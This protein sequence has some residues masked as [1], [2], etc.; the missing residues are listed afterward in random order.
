MYLFAVQLFAMESVAVNIHTVKS[1][2]LDLLISLSL[3]SRGE[4]CKGN[5]INTA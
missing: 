3:R 2:I 4:G 1:M 5:K